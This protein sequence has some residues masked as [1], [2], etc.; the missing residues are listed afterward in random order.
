VILLLLNAVIVACEDVAQFHVSP[1]EIGY[2]L[3]V[4]FFKKCLAIESLE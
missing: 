2:Q 4:M 1:A 3:L